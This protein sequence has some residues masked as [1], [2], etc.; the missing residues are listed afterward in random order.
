VS[1]EVNDMLVTAMPIK[2]K[3]KALRTRA[4]LTQQALAV[5]AGLSVSAVIH[6][7]AGRIPDPRIS[8][9]KALAEAL[10]CRIDDLAINGGDEPAPKPSPRRRPRKPSS[11]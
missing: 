2:D 9:L 7:E 3:L 10:G 8:T 11:N 6:I 5:K 1:L 4:G